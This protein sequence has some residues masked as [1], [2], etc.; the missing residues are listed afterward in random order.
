MCIDC[1]L[2]KYQHLDFYLTFY[3]LANVYLYM[4]QNYN[5]K[6]IK[7]ELED[8]YDNGI[9]DIDSSLNIKLKIANFKYLSDSNHNFVNIKYTNTIELDLNDISNLKY[10]LDTIIYSI[11]RYCELL[12]FNDDYI[13]P[14]SEPKHKLP[15][16]IYKNYLIRFLLRMIK[17]YVLFNMLNKKLLKNHRFFNLV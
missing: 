12:T 7:K 14:Y 16:K 1:Y 8:L 13:N 15:I 9:Y 17:I 2:H 6:D 3:T 11:E 4:L 10:K 5:I